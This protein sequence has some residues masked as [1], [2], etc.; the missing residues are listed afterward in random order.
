[1]PS[2]KE[3]YQRN[4]QDTNFSSGISESHDYNAAALASALGTMGDTLVEADIAKD[5]RQREQFTTEEADRAIAG[6]TPEDLAK[7]DRMEALQ[8]SDKGYDLTD[9]PYAM[10]NLERSIGQVV[11]VNTK[12]N[13]LA[14]LTTLPKT[15][16]EGVKGYQDAANAAYEAQKGN[17]KNKAAFDS[18]FYKTFLEDTAKVATDVRT[19]IATETR[20]TGQRVASVKFNSLISSSSSM[21]PETFKNSFEVIARETQLYYKDS[22]EAA[23]AME[24]VLK[25]MSDNDAT[26]ANLN[27]IRDVKFFGDHKIGD[28]ISFSDYYKTI[29]KKAT[30]MTVENL[31]KQYAHSDG[32]LDINAAEKVARNLYLNPQGSKGTE[33]GTFT[34]LQ[35]VTSDTLGDSYSLGTDGANRTW[36]C[37]LWTKAM[38]GEVG[39]S[40]KL[41]TVDDQFKQLEGEG[42]VF[43]DASQLQ[44]GDMVFWKNTSSQA[45]DAYKRI[46]HA[47]IYMGNNKVRQAGTQGVA[48]I[49]LGLYEVE[50]YGKTSST[51]VDGTASNYDPD[52]YDKVMAELK[53]ADSDARRTIR[54]AEAKSKKDTLEGA[55]QAGS[56]GAGMALVDNSSLSLTDKDTIKRSLKT[57]YDMEDKASKGTLTAMQKWAVKYEGPT[58]KLWED[59]RYYEEFKDKI[60]SDAEERKFQL[61]VNNLDNY[62][63]ASNGLGDKGDEYPDDPEEKGAE[64]TAKIQEAVDNFIG[65]KTP[66]KE[67]IEGIA[68][69][70]V[71]NGLDF[72]TEL[73]K[74]DWGD[75]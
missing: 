33:V 17:I 44:P 31:K 11:A 2:T 41:R 30:R 70:C 59:T 42:K 72:K 67:I 20:Q 10:A 51:T 32:T 58:G 54:Q 12:E 5:R 49:D 8:H 60:R 36:D 27:A 3:P 1:M 22:K 46:T 34:A 25:G 14:G 56:L 75:Y 13:Y 21:T 26:T 6:K 53:A 40:L 69:Y 48:D 64:H 16:A 28:E 52:R 18:G 4:L 74:V 7:Y 24:K 65:I 50:G 63:R 39:V 68:E 55:Y 66:K 47:G 15:V 61:V 45:D 38:M 19:R 62:Y 43:T 57:H 37:G 9:N 73:D 23:D 29:A 35:K 71:E